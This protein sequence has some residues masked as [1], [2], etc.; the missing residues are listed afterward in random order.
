MYYSLLTT[1]SDLPKQVVWFSI[2]AFFM[3][4]TAWKNTASTWVSLTRGFVSMS[5]VGMR[6]LEEAKSSPPTRALPSATQASLCQQKKW[7]WAG[8]WQLSIWQAAKVC[9]LDLWWSSHIRPTLLENHEGWQSSV[10][11]LSDH[12]T[13]V[14]CH[15]IGVGVGWTDVQRLLF[16]DIMDIRGTLD[17]WHRIWKW[18]A[19]K[20][21]QQWGVWGCGVL[22]WSQVA[23]LFVF[24]N[25]ES[26]KLAA[27][28]SE[29]SSKH[30][31]REI[32]INFL[33][34]KYPYWPIRFSLA[35]HKGSYLSGSAVAVD[36]PTEFPGPLQLVPSA[37]PKSSPLPPIFFFQ[38]KSNN[39]YPH[40]A[41]SQVEVKVEIN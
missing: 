39:F 21:L 27:P 31:R 20:A 13:V 14:G 24:Q 6:M 8:V 29:A 37:W 12:S 38:K 30:C 19:L 5:L 23:L 15:P 32:I 36:R 22:G 41:H 35:R 9:H 18:G 17:T 28:A 40:C 10:A 4:L 2:D 7:D 25:G 16:V 1:F 3:R 33:T 34:L 26:L 11:L